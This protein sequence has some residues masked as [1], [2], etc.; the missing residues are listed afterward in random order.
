MESLWA[1]LP[2]EISSKIFRR[3]PNHVQLMMRWNR[4]NPDA[5]YE[6]MR[7]CIEHN[8][9]DQLRWIMLHYRC[10]HDVWGELLISR[11]IEYGRLDV[12]EWASDQENIRVSKRIWEFATQKDQLPILEW[13]WERKMVPGDLNM[14]ARLAAQYGRVRI[15]EWA[16]EHGLP[17]DGSV[18]ASAASNGHVN[19]LE[20]AREYGL[21]MDESVCVSAARIGHFNVL[22][23]ARE[24]G[25][26]CDWIQL[27]RKVCMSIP[28]HYNCDELWRQHYLWLAELPILEWIAARRDNGAEI[29]LD[30][31]EAHRDYEVNAG[32]EMHLGTFYQ[33]MTRNGF[34]VERR[35]VRVFLKCSKF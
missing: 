9:V 14:I 8:L 35:G 1:D 3:L 10:P 25:C 26:P 4:L 13:C 29:S 33:V 17:M 28:P 31:E 23:W 24:H 15:L 12:V 5:K 16:R 27:R 30:L 19:V 6:I 2:I 18:C 34:K 11:A 21:P 32:D 7:D 22:M 20:W